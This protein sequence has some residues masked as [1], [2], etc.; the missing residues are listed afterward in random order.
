ML[1]QAQRRKERRQALP[2]AMLIQVMCNVNR[3]SK[4]RPQPFDLDEILSWL[5]YPPE[6]AAQP[7][8]PASPEALR[9][10]LRMAALVFSKSNGQEG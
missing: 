7:P 9:E 2:V 3:D 8:E 6:P 4:T 5:G 10:K 1:V